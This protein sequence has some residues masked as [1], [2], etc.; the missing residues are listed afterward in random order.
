MPLIWEPIGTDIDF[1]LNPREWRFIGAAGQQYQFFKVNF[2]VSDWPLWQTRVNA[3]ASI[4]LPV[5]YANET[6]AEQGTRFYI[7]QDTYYFESPLS[8]KH[9]NSGFIDRRVE[10]LFTSRWRRTP[11]NL[12]STSC[13]LWGS[14]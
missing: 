4:R 9:L 7:S 3:W 14:A 12:F 1:H 8:S 10:L 2:W 6:L 13:S 5:V 11:A